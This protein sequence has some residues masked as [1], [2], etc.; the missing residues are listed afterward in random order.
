MCSHCSMICFGSRG[1]G[2]SQT[3]HQ[4]IWVNKC[5]PFIMLICV[6][7]YSS[8]N[9]VNKIS[10]ANVKLPLPAIEMP[11]TLTKPILNHPIVYTYTSEILCT[12]YVVT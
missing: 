5:E 8:Q 10:Y 2:L 6:Y 4:V 3:G 12:Y 1:L 7:T 9:Y 11:C